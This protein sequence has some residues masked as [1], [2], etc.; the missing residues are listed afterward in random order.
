MNATKLARSLVRQ[1]MELGISDFVISSGSRNA[2]LLIALGEAVEKKLI[3]LHVKLDER[4]AAFFAL[5]ISK[6][7]NNYV[8]VVCTSGTA[9]ANYAPAALE[10]VHGGNKLIFITADRPARL[11]KTGAN[12]TTN[13][14]NLYQ[15][16][17]THDISSEIVL[18]NILDG[19]PVHLN[20]QFDEPLITEEKE[21]WLQGLNMKALQFDNKISGELKVSSGVVVIGHDRAGYSRQ[22][23]V[24][25]I[26]RLGWPVISEDPLS[27]PT[28]I[29]HAS[30]FLADEVVRDFLEPENI[31]SIGR[32]TLSRSI[33][34]FV[35]KSKYNIVIDPRVKN[36]DANRQADELL[37]SLPKS[38]ISDPTNQDSWEKVS[39]SA[40][41]EINLLNWSEQQVVAYIC[42][43]LP[44]NSALFIGSSRP[45]RDIEAFARPRDGIEVF[46]NRGLAGI[47]GNISTIFGIAEK[48]NFT[49]AILGDLALLHDISALANAPTSN[50]R[51]YVIDNNGGGIFST[52]PQSKASNFEKLFGTPH[53]LDLLKILSGFGIKASK[54]SD[55]IDLESSLSSQPFGLEIIIVG[56]PSRKENAEQLKKITQRVS[57]AVR[58]GINLA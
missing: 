57:S 20:V 14:I 43:H 29:P 1:M 54:V 5:G 35:N 38:V 18:I 33:N 53:D 7:S 15:F 4:G 26:S 32:T 47:D 28:S 6:A 2:P 17:P 36:I 10:S 9:A 19:R 37:S 21:N 12:Q 39:E 48:F 46:A 44:H 56:V 24:S 55:L 40:A 23:I 51:I 52:L 27:F 30:L 16:I 49:Y 41:S 45:I 13:Q 34:N 42:K 25:F 31:I 3:S 50:L 22:D 58:M 8:A 11:R